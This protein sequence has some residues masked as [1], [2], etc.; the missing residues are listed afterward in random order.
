MIYLS[1]PDVC[2]HQC[3]SWRVGPHT[4]HMAACRPPRRPGGRESGAPSAQ[5]LGRGLRFKL[6]FGSEQ[7]QR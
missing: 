3:V 7:D 4:G 5:T 1:C 6:N 2:V